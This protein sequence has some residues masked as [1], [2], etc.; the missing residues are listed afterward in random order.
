MLIFKEIIEERFGAKFACNKCKD[1]RI[2]DTPEY[3]LYANEGQNEMAFSDLDE[4]VNKYVS[5]PISLPHVTQM[6]QG[7]VKAQK[8]DSDCTPK[9]L[10]V[11]L[12]Q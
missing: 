1:V 6:V 11:I 2:P 9:T 4:K 5:T 7:M 3:R 12:T 10:T 8:Q